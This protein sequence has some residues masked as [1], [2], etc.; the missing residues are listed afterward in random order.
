MFRTLFLIFLL[1]MLYKLVF[2]FIIPVYNASKRMR[3]QV[4]DMQQKM[5][6]EQQRRQFEK[7]G[8]IKPDPQVNTAA[9][10]PADRDY[11]DFE[12]VK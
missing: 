3:D 11:I 7:E 4:S 10:K 8:Y 6:E 2:E 1:Y 5:Q 9:A 12:E